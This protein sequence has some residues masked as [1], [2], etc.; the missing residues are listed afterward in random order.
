MNNKILQ[1]CLDALNADKPDIS[2]IK[3]MIETLLALSEG[4]KVQ[5][6]DPVPLAGGPKVVAPPEA[7]DMAARASI[8]TIKAM[9][10]ANTE[11]A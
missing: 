5:V 11:Q 9:A 6:K 3:G 8:E 1:K 10:E 2:Y 7:I 4:D